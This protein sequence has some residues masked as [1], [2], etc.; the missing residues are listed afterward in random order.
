MDIQYSVG[1]NKWKHPYPYRGGA[2]GGQNQSV[3]FHFFFA[4]KLWKPWDSDP[5]AQME[6]SSK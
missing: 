2:G 5:I 4:W 6:F 3:E 1:G